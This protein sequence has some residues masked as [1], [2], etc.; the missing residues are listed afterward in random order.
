MELFYNSISRVLS[1]LNEEPVAEIT[2]KYKTAQRKFLERNV[3][4]RLRQHSPVYNGDT[5]HTAYLSEATIWFP[6]G[7]VMELSENTMAQIFVNQDKDLIADLMEGE[8]FIDSSNS[9]K[10]VILSSKGVEVTVSSGSSISAKKGKNQEEMF[11]SVESGNVRM[12][13]GKILSEG[14]SFSVENGNAKVSEVSVI[15]PRPNSKYLYHHEGTESIKFS[16]KTENLNSENKLQLIVARDRKFEDVVKELA[17]TDIDS[18]DVPLGNGI[19]YW[20]IVSDEIQLSAGK[21]QVVQSLLPVGITPT[22]NFEYSFRSRNPAVRFIWSESPYAASYKL[23]VADNREMMNPVIEQRV[24]SASAIISTLDEGTWWWQVEPYYTIN[25]TGYV[26][27][28]TTKVFS[29]SK[30]GI[31]EKPELFIPSDNSFVNTSPDAKNVAFSWKSISDA[32]SYSLVVSENERMSSPVLN[33][34]TDNNYFKIS[35]TDINFKEGKYFWTVIA[36]DSEG[37]VS[38]KVTGR[39]FYAMKG[40]PE[41]HLVEPA[42]GYLV[43]QSL[44]QDTKFT[45]KKNL[46]ENWK[47]EI[48]VSADE[49]FSD[50]TIC[51]ETSNYSISFHSLPI[52]KYYWRLVST[53]LLNGFVL[54]TPGREINVVDSLDKAEII[55]PLKKAVVRDDVPN[56]FKWE[57][58]EG[59]DFYKVTIYSGDGNNIVYENNVYDTS[60]E[61]NLY[62]SPIWIDKSTYRMEIQ[63]KAMAVPGVSSR[64]SG[65]ISES[66]FQVLYLRP[67]EVVLPKKDSKI[68]GIDALINPIHAKWESVEDVSFAQLVLTKIDGKRRNVVLK[69]PSDGNVYSGNKIAPNDVVLDTEE[70]LRSGLYEIVVH[71]K[72]IDGIDI[73]STGPKHIVRF[74]VL[75]VEPL[76][77]AKGLKSNPESFDVEYLSNLDNPRSIKFTWEKISGATDYDVEILTSSRKP[78]TIIK[79]RVKTNSMDLD[80]LKLSDSERRKLMNGEFVWTVSAIRRSEKKILQT[81]KV[82]RSKFRTDVPEPKKTTAKGAKNPYGKK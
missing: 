62:N 38:D 53:N 44:L 45:W 19:Y 64:R 46:G 30:K 1:K 12:E 9:Q 16:W 52:G 67:V 78:E 55:T 26:K 8:A 82:S 32:V 28:E 63:A 42:N 48:Q 4:D 34:E 49:N 51:E 10:D 33:K 39:Y 20:K 2:F 25:N 29:I 40:I 35:P 72:T 61:L 7:N 21:F 74:T 22:E 58:V 23:T 56:V 5:I 6:D 18:I 71:A 81:G 77:E 15:S 68:K 57:K 47:T 41:Q 54:N 65:K 36:K 69:V 60:F 43:A 37:N 75:P 11:L 31:L 70:G 66:V 79:K 3:W 73:S 50:L 59:A 17:I 80:F 14:T 13:N 24:S 76:P 27:A